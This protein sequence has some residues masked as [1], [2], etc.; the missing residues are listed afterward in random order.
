[1]FKTHNDA[2]VMSQENFKAHFEMI[3]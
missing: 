2:E 1:M 3:F